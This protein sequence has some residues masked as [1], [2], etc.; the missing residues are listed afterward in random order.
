[1]ATTT[2]KEMKNTAG[3]DNDSDKSI[4]C[5]SQTISTS[6][7]LL[8]LGD[9]KGIRILLLLYGRENVYL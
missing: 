3:C 9:S 7:D 5:V 6:K 4:E 2:C 8:E 1:M